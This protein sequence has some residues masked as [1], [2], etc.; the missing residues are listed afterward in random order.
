M[1][2]KKEL[3]AIK[4]GS[5]LQLKNILNYLWKML[6]QN[7]LILEQKE[8]NKST[9]EKIVELQEKGLSDIVKDMHITFKFGETEKYPP[10][11]M[12]KEFKVKVV[13]YA[14]DGKNSGFQIELPEELRDF[15]QNQNGPHITVSLGEIDGVKGKAVDTGT[16]NFE[17]IEEPI[18]I[19]GK[20]GYFVFGKGKIMDNSI[21]EEEKKMEK[22][23]N[24]EGMMC[25][26]CQKHVDKALNSIE[27]VEATVD[28]KNN[29]AYLKLSH[30]VDES[31]LIKAVEDAGYSVKGFE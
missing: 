14:S 3:L 25:P 18:E 20:L 23:M 31:I 9:Q 29:C 1:L 19:P 13:G 16:L 2:Q 24:I 17:P 10:E 4:G 28:L 5:C 30:D 8:N 6:T 21:F 7:M 15:Y 26:N 22:T 11:L 27:G 12:G